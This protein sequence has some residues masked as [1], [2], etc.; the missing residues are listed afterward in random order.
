LVHNNQPER[1]AAASFALAELPADV[2]DRHQYISVEVVAWRLDIFNLQVINPQQHR[3][4]L[5]G[6]D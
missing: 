2:I 6:E 1:E 5:F 3:S 4:L